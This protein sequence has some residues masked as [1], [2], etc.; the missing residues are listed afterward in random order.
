[1][2]KVETKY[3][4][5]FS[6]LAIFKIDPSNSNLGQP[7]KLYSLVLNDELKMVLLIY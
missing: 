3:D 2:A 5:F 6:N 4:Y 1:M 7:N